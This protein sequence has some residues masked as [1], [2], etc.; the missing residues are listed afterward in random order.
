MTP[1][2]FREAIIVAYNE[3]TPEG[4]EQPS[5]GDLKRFFLSLLAEGLSKEDTE[6]LTKFFNPINQYP[7]LETGIKRYE[8]DKLKPLRKFIIGETEQ[9]RE[10]IVK[11]LAIL[12]DFK[13]RPYSKW[14]EEC[15]IIPKE[16]DELNQSKQKSDVSSSIVFITIEDEP[17]DAQK[18]QNR[19]TEI[20][21]RD[22]TTETKAKIDG[23]A[24]D[25]SATVN[26]TNTKKTLPNI[27]I[28]ILKSRYRIIITY[29]LGILVACSGLF[30]YFQK[31]NKGCMIWTGY[32]YERTS[33]DKQSGKPPIV[34]Y[35]D[36]LYKQMTRIEDPN[37]LTKNDIGST[38]YAI[39]QKDSLEF[40]TSP[41]YHPLNPNKK[42]KPLTEY[43][44]NKYVKESKSKL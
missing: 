44:L 23:Q 33:C 42:L 32:Q 19:E 9:P 12:I 15:Q 29:S 25:Q 13:P 3:N 40:Y 28:E 24:V 35:N 7:D 43:I 30:F 38:W 26:I 34:T 11:L 14:K 39:I 20:R 18:M 10:I 37:T 21:E 16:N 8:L 5:P 27:Y 36:S 2:K 41:G 1:D 22:N 31:S 4:L 17:L 6:T